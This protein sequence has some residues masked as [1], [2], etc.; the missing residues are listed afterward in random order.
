MIFTSPLMRA[1]QTAEAAR[2]PELPSAE[3]KVTD[4]L[5]PESSPE[6]VYQALSAPKSAESAMLVT[7]YLLPGHLISNILVCEPSIEV[8]N[9]AIVYIESKWKPN[10]Y[11]GTLKWLLPQMP[12]S[13]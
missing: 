3:I 7:H 10:Q 8:R 5:M 12:R 4:A 6:D 9:G 11:S 2:E 1:V 13:N